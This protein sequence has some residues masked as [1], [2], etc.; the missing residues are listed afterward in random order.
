MIDC[1]ISTLDRTPNRKAWTRE[2]LVKLSSEPDL[3][4]TV[5]DAG[6]DVKQLAWFAEN[7]FVVVPQPREGSLFRRFLLAE[8]LAQSEFYLMGDNDCLPTSE[9]WLQKGLDV[10]ASHPGY[11]YI[12]YRLEHCDFPFDHQHSD[13]DIRSIAKGGGLAVV[14]RACRKSDFRIPILFDPSNADDKQYCEAIRKSGLLVG[15]F[16]KLYVRHLGREESTVC[17]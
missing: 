4:L 3:R 17:Q 11:G 1:F 9:F 7:G 15:M 2:T 14:R 8:V 5:L 6:S 13:A 12:V 16:E 10:A